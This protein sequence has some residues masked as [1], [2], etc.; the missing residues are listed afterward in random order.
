MIWDA[1]FDLGLFDEQV[2]AN[3]IAQYYRVRNKYGVPLDSRKSFTKSDWLIWAS[4]LDDSGEVTKAFAK[5]LTEMLSNTKNRVP[6][7]DWYETKTAKLCWM[8]HRT[9]L[10]G[11][12][13][14][15]LRAEKNTVFGGT[16]RE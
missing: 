7:T 1:I 3:E 6:F 5:D 4:A 14:P 11:L 15:L 8:W 2:A 16:K 13:M 12:W 10:G 9:V